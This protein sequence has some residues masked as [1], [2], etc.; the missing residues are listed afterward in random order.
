MC[1]CVGWGCPNWG[2]NF[3]DRLEA[4]IF[5]ENTFWSCQGCTVMKVKRNFTGKQ[6][7]LNINSLSMKANYE[8]TFDFKYNLWKSWDTLT[9]SGVIHVHFTCGCSVYGSRVNPS[10]LPCLLSQSG[11]IFQPVGCYTVGHL[12]T[13]N[14]ITSL[15]SQTPIHTCPVKSGLQKTP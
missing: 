15:R 8:Y 9:P 12:V 4:N 10:C 13:S 1:E 2:I 5:L 3:D 11:L 14:S 7:S 6:D